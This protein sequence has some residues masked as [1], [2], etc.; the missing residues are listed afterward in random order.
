PVLVEHD[1]GAIV[2]CSAGWSAVALEGAT[3]L[4]RNLRREE[5]LR[6]QSCQLTTPTIQQ[7]RGVN[8]AAV[9]ER[10]DRFPRT[11]LNGHEPRAQRVEAF[12]ARHFRVDTTRHERR[13]AHL[14]RPHL[15]M[16]AGTEVD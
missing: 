11:L 7:T 2:G 1:A 9:L 6:E 5:S 10:I 8:V 3:I 13:N 16:Q 12:A 15:V 14:S 4:R